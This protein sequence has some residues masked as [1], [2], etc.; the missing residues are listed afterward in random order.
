MILINKINERHQNFKK[1][2]KAESCD[3]NHSSD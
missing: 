2:T 3:K 1:K